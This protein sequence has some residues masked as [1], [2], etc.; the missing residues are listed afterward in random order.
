[1]SR[2]IA[3]LYSFGLEKY[4]DKFPP[5]TTALSSPDGLLAAGGDLELETILTAYARGIFPWF[6]EGQPIL[7]WSPDPRLVL[8]LDKF[9]LSRSLNKTLRKGIFNISFDTAFS[10][11]V[12]SCSMPRSGKSQSS[13]ITPRMQD[14]YENLY[15]HGHAHS[16]EC[17]REDKLCGGLYGVSIGKIFYG[18]SM[19]SLDTDASKVALATLCSVGKSWGYLFIDCQVESAHMLSLGAERMERT[20]FSDSLKFATKQ[21]ISSVAWR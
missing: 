2:D 21:H 14:A 20:V 18:E 10:E 4:T 15:R 9:K 5:I 3:N 13:W 11:V 8:Y 19:F 6:E 12:R 16:V 7:W 17:W 1:M